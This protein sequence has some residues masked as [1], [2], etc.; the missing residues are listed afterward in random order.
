[1]KASFPFVEETNFST[2]KILN[3][4]I[5]GV[6]TWR[7]GIVPFSMKGASVDFEC[8]H[9]IFGDFDPLGILVFVESGLKSH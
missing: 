7:K 4:S 6:R 2:C 9:L 1:M 5:Y 3:L 8:V